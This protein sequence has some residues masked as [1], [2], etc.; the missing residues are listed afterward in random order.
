MASK[1]K[2]KDYLDV[3][4]DQ[5]TLGSM[6]VSLRQCDG[7]TQKDLAAK[8]GVSKQ[9]LSNVENNRK[10]VGIKFVRKVAEALS[11]PVEPFLELLVRDQI[12]K[13]GLQVEVSIKAS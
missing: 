8:L 12:A 11:Y 13:E 3:V 9:F 5:V 2:Q 10:S 4:W 7:I 6:I 1:K